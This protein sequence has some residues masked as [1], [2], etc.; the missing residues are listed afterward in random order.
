MELA[1]LAY[2]DDTGYHYADYPTFLAYYQSK[3]RAIYGE[4]TYLES[5]S[6][7]GQ[8]VA[9]EAKAAYDTAVLNAATVNSFS[10]ATGQGLGLSRQVKINGISRRV[11]S[12]S[13]ADVVIVGQSGTS[14]VGGVVIDTLQQKW[15]VPDT[16]IPISGMITVTVTAQP[17]GAISAAAN[18]I[19][20]IF[21]P[22]RGWQ[23]VTNPDPATEG[24]PVETD[25][26]LRIRQT[27]SVAIPSLTVL[28]GTVGAVE[29]L[30]G[31]TKARG[32][33]NDTGVT[34]GNGIPAHKISLVVKGGDAT[35]IAEA[36]ALHKTPGTG[37]Y[38]TTSELVYDTH[39]MP[40]LINFYRPTIATIS[41]QITLSVGPDW[42]ADF[43]PLIQQAVADYINSDKIGA[44][45][46]ITKLYAP[47][48]LQGSIEGMSYDIVTLLTKKNA[49]SF[50]DINIV[51]TFNE[52]A[53]CDP[54]DVDVIVT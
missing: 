31:V 48:Y 49:G 5:D 36:I 43:I 6:Q 24:A 39:G 20:G 45:V 30:T 41:A 22:T 27:Q 51:L 46:L 4:D 1:D 3:Y 17:D 33:E 29:N 10:P 14:I 47:A 7:D 53:E 34:D 16:L 9:V 2:I 54:A 21:T 11:P 38:G 26:E 18:T 44:P 13:T 42:S 28:E 37:T 50:D 23:T 35:E 52:D 32:Y 12:R 25:A 19:T 40:L 15:D 8:W